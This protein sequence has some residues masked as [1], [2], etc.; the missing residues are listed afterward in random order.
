MA[1]NVTHGVAAMNREDE[2][3]RLMRRI[4]DA[5]FE[6]RRWRDMAGWLASCHASILASL[7]PRTTKDLRRRCTGV[8]KGFVLFFSG[9]PPVTGGVAD[10]YHGLPLEECVDRCIKAIDNHGLAP[11]AGQRKRGPRR[12]TTKTTR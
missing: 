5:E 8:C 12:K 6:L 9:Q 1:D 4:D 3:A 2:I 7:S 10:L 11:L